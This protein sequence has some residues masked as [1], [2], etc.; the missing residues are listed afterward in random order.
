M[1]PADLIL[2]TKAPK[3]S[4]V[5]AVPVHPV[6]A[7]LLREW[8][9]SGWA[10]WF[11]RAPLPDDLICPSRERRNGE[12]WPRHVSRGNAAFHEDLDA[13]GMRRRRQHDAR[14]TFRSLCL[15]DGARRDLLQ[16]ATH[17]RP[18]D[19]GGLYETPEWRAVCEEVAKL[20]IT[21]ATGKIIALPRAAAGGADGSLVQG[22]VQ[23]ANGDENPSLFRAAGMGIVGGADGSRT[24]E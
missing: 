24:R 22:L 14:R 12:L 7:K 8:K 11:G 10:R 19:V 15:S 18:G 17:G 5:R 3:A 2:G 1:A 13:L 21:L 4:K 9:L 20:K 16:W 23:S 6:L